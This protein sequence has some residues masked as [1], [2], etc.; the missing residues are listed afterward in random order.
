MT[1]QMRKHVTE[2]PALN[3][4]HRQAQPV[5]ACRCGIAAPAGL[6]G[7]LRGWPQALPIPL[8]TGNCQLRRVSGC[9]AGRGAQKT[10]RHL[11]ML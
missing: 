8:E 9:T 2:T 5:A 1:V 3:A 6:L 10:C 11:G 4:A 7:V